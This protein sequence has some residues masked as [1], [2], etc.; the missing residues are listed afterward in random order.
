MA[1]LSQAHFLLWTRLTT[2]S[3]APSVTK[4]EG[5]NPQ[6][7]VMVYSST[8]LICQCPFF[9]QHVS[10][11]LCAFVCWLHLHVS[12]WSF[13]S[14]VSLSWLALCLYHFLCFCH[15]QSHCCSIRLFPP[16]HPHPFR[17][18]LPGVWTGGMRWASPE[19]STRKSYNRGCRPGS[20][21]PNW[22]QFVGYTRG[23]QSAVD[24]KQDI[25]EIHGPS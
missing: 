16:Q 5:M 23:G 17:L 9:L 13:V 11:S 2:A 25:M 12:A 10:V 4:S 15:S 24:I 19:N 6:P 8:S 20:F 14:V 18:L 21:L 3:R 22:C 1:A 7:T